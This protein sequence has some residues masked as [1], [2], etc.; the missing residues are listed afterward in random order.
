MKHIRQ[1]RTLI[2]ATLLTMHLKVNALSSQ[3][4]TLS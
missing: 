3:R 2:R 4:L 1:R